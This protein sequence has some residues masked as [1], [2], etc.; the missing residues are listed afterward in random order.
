MAAVIPAVITGIESIPITHQ[1]M[2]IITIRKNAAL[3]TA[4]TAA[5]ESGYYFLRAI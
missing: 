3:L 4:L 5:E 2:G 1:S